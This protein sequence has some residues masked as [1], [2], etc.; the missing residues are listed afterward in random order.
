MSYLVDTMICSAYLKG[1][2]VVF[3]RFVQHGGRLAVSTITVGELYVWT[4]RSHA[5]ADRLGSLQSLLNDMTVLDVTHEVAARFGA[6]RAEL[7]DRGRPIPQL[8]LFIAATALVHN[9]VLVTH[10]VKDF[11]G[12]ADLTVVDWLEP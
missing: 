1:S 11:S 10:N 5:P 8:D 4:H 3:P 2:A 12:I 7:L 9:L 6:I